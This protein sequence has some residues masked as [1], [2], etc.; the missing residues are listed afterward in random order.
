MTNLQNLLLICISTLIS[1][2]I[3]YYLRNGGNSKTLF[4]VCIICISFFLSLPLFSQFYSFFFNKVLNLPDARISILTIMCFGLSSINLFLL[5]KVS[6]Q[7][8][9]LRII[10]RE[11]ALISFKIEKI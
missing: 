7:E 4:Y 8:T 6:K 3:F 10:N 9:Q 11:L 2:S 5:S 1:S